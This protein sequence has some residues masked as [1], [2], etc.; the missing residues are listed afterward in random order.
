MNKDVTQMRSASLAWNGPVAVFSHR[1][2]LA[3]NAL[4][5]PLRLD[6]AEMVEAVARNREIR[7]LII[8]GSEG[9]FCAGGDLRAMHERQASTDPEVNSSDA[10]RRRLD[11]AQGWLRKLRDLDIPVVA[12]VDGPAYGAGFCLALL[13]D[14]I[15]VSSRASFCMSF[16]KVGCLPD[17][18]AFHTLPRW[19]GM[20]RAKELM[21]TGRRLDAQEAHALGLALAIHEPQRLLPETQ[22]FAERLARGPREAIAF[23]RK[24]LNQ[25][26]ETDYVTLAALEASAQA[27]CMAAPWHREAVAGFL[28]GQP[29]PYDWDRPARPS[30]Q[31]PDQDL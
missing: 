8:T 9:S 24:L 14:F 4:S 17:F 31:I 27:I 15:M 11:W 19:I 16:V 25:S 20:A 26:Y 30:P 29:A 6:Y 2:A 21:I 5:E 28:N 22:A 23:T 12:A 18:G 3:R 7:A 13:A 10:T 1:N